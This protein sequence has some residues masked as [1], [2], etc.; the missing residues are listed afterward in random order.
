MDIVIRVTATVLL[1]MV[2]FML[3]ISVVTSFSETGKKRANKI[4][5]GILIFCEIAQVFGVIAIWA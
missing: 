2:F 3:G 5:Q 1:A 4:I